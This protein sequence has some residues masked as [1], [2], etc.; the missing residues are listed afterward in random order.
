[1]L[2]AAATALVCLCSMS[3]SGPVPPGATVAVTGATGKLGR[4]AVKQL[5]AAGFKA[6]CLVR[7]PIGGEDKTRSFAG[8]SPSL[9]PDAP[10]EAVAAYLASLPGVDI[11]RGDVTDV[12]SCSELLRDTDACLALHG[13]RRMSKLT[14]LVPWSSKHTEEKT[15][16]KQVNYEGVRNLI[17]AAKSV[18]TVKRIVRITGK[19]EDPWSPFSILINGLGSMAKAYNYE[20][21]VL[22][23]NAGY[24]VEYTIIRP[25]VMGRGDEDLPEDRELVLADDGADL[26]VSPI[27]HASVASLCVA[28]LAFGNAGRATLTAMTAPRGDGACTFEPLLAS[29]QPD[30]RQFPPS[31]LRQHQLA[32]RV[33]GS[34]IAATLVSVAATAVL[35]ARKLL[36]RV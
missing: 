4:L 33:G 26:K 21:E 36:F 16:S 11:V 6:R 13:A 31:L 35:M 5:V 7:H 1:M 2:G 34:A 30:R 15:H 32:V 22:L 10:K 29:V 27:P 9:A 24:E 25:G 8:V 3:A 19:G 23:R 28:S 18:G 20:G 14:D 17:N 12:A